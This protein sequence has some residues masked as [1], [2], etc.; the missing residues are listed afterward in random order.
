M[1]WWAAQARRAAERDA[2]W[3]EQLDALREQLEGRMLQ[4]HEEHRERVAQLEEDEIS[5]CGKGDFLWTGV[6]AS[7]HI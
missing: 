4:Q 2:Y 1:R 6:A 7:L 3:R 5:W